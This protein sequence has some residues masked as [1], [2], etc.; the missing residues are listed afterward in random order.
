MEAKG[1][2]QDNREQDIYYIGAPEILYF[3]VSSYSD[4]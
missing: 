4:L 3:L 1:Y 2:F